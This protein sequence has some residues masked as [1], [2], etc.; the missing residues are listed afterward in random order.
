GD[1]GRVLSRTRN[2]DHA[3]SRIEAQFISSGL[4]ALPDRDRIGEARENRSRV[5]GIEYPDLP[6]CAA[7][8]SDPKLDDT[9]GLMDGQQAVGSVG[10]VVASEARES[11]VDELGQLVGR[12]IDDVDRLVAAVCQVVLSELRIDPADVKRKERLY[13]A[14]S[15]VSNTGVV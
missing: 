5:V 1:K 10:I 3:I 11:P 4:P 14:S 6:R 12:R 2:Y 7:G 9:V 8:V 15:L 13:T